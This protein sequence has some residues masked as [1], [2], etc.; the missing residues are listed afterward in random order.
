MRKKVNIKAIS[1]EVLGEIFEEMSFDENLARQLGMIDNHPKLTEEQ[2]REYHNKRVSMAF[3]REAKRRLGDD[4][5][6]LK[7]KH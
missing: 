7:E 4:L 1:S 2:K 5:P 6:Y 3:H